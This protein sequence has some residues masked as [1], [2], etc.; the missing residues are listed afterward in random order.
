[1]SELVFMGNLLS[2]RG[3]GP[4][5]VIDEAVT[6]ARRPESASEIQ[7]NACY[8]KNEEKLGRSFNFTFR[9]IDDVFSLNNAKLDDFVDRIYPISGLK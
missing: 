7:E 5:N 3:I 2:A 9:Y 6:C 1:M 4:G 8:K